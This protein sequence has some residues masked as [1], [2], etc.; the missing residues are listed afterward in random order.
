MS[1]ENCHNAV[2]KTGGGFKQ[3]INHAQINTWYMRVL[4]EHLLGM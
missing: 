4:Y 1:K 3:V 2:S